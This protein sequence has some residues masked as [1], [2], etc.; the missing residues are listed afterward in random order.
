MMDSSKFP[1]SS[2][3]VVSLAQYK[4]G[5]PLK[6]VKP[7][8]PEKPAL[9]LKALW[10]NYVDFKRPSVSP[11]YIKK[12]FGRIYSVLNQIPDAFIVSFN[13]VAIRDFL[14]SLHKS[15]QTIK[16]CLKQ[17]SACCNW[18]VT[19]GL[20][21]SNPFQQMA[22]RIKI[23]KSVHSSEDLEINP[24]TREERDMIIKAIETDCFTSPLARKAK[25]S[26]YAPYIKFLF[27]T[28]CRPSEAIA[29]QWKHIGLDFI[30]FEQSV[31]LGE[32]GLVLK[33]GL[34]TEKS[35]KF[36]INSQLAEILETIKNEEN[37]PESFVFSAPHGGDYLDPITFRKNTW[38]KVLEGLGITY[39]KPYQ[40][41]HTFITLCLEKGI[42]AKDIA[43][44]VG[45][46]P[47]II[48]QH[49]AG[50]KRDLQV[51]D[52]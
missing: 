31:V 13:A 6:L 18:G 28:G 4:M 35:R 21:K 2:K 16:I 26:F 42:D 7:S 37:S 24:F 30:T 48:Y 50:N 25:H 34:K 49:Y 8:I 45:N 27:F 1:K 5:K 12:D 38:K 14:L 19:S 23:E 17:L 29:L 39:R 40:T 3:D 36:P 47:H 51:P 52:L 44:W 46:S 10:N 15:D 11:S 32:E 33:E 43:R 22:S 41:R 9:D 20:I